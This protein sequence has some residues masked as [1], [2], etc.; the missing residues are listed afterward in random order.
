MGLHQ[1]WLKLLSFTVKSYKIHQKFKYI[2]NAYLQVDTV[3]YFWYMH[4]KLSPVLI[5]FRKLGAF[6][7]GKPKCLVIHTHLKNVQ[8]DFTQEKPR[9]FGH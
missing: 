4:I 3:K 8:K 7:N 1:L 2:C 6:F 5:W 9:N